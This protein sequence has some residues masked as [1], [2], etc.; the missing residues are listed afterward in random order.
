MLDRDLHELHAHERRLAMTADP[1]ANIPNADDSENGE[2][3]PARRAQPQRAAAVADTDLNWEALRTIM[4]E[5]RT[6]WAKLSVHPYDYWAG[7]AAAA[8]AVLDS[9]HTLER[10]KV[11]GLAEHTQAAQQKIIEASR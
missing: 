5:D 6:R 1:F 10:Y 4:T 11:P 8:Q 3:S 9:M 7:H 2:F